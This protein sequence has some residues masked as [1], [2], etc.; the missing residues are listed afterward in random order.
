MFDGATGLG[1][2]CCPGPSDAAWIA[3]FGTRRLMAHLREGN[4]PKD[5]L[6]H[7]L[8]DAEKSFAGLRKRPPKEVYEIPFA[9]MMFVVADDSG[10]DALWFGDCAALVLRPTGPLEVVGEAFEKRAAEAQRVKMMAEAKGLAPAAGLTRAEILPYP[11]RAEQ[12]EFGCRQLA[13]RSGCPRGRLRCGEA[14][15]CAFGVAG[16]ALL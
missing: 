10:F 12:S 5:A 1:E 13:I 9:S 4:E 8:A 2:T 14:Y 15:R 16:V 3:Q 6:R 11:R 7:T